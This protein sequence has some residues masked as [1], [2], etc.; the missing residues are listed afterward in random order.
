M[1]VFD[2]TL[3]NPEHLPVHVLYICGKET[4]FLCKNIK[5]AISIAYI[6]YPFFD[7]AILNFFIFYLIMDEF[8][9]VV[10]FQRN[11]GST[12]YGNH[13]IVTQNGYFLS[14]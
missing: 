6:L 12:V 13:F 3:H 5:G 8:Y 2:A 1:F 9:K 7:L 11:M 14:H 4:Y 10:C